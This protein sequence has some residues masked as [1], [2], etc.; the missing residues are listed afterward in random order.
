MNC[1]EDRWSADQTVHNALYYRI[2]GVQTTCLQQARRCLTGARD[3][4]MGHAAKMLWRQE[5]HGLHMTDIG[6]P[7]PG[8]PFLLHDAVAGPL[9]TLPLQQM[10]HP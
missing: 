2:A 6:A 10:H 4:K 8:C 1:G 5:R 9:S 3:S 7:S